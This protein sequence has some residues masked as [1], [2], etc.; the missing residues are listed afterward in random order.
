MAIP[1]MVRLKARV[2]EL[3][4]RMSG[5]GWIAGGKM[6]PGRALLLLTGIVLLG[7]IAIFNEMSPNAQASL[8][9]DRTARASADL[10]PASTLSTDEVTGNTAGSPKHAPVAGQG[11]E[12]NKGENDA[13]P[14]RVAAPAEP[15]FANPLWGLPLARLSTTRERPIFSA[16]R[17]P[18]APTPTYVAPV[19]VSQ[20]AKPPEPERPAIALVGTIIGTDDGYRMAVFR[21]TSTQDVLRLRIGENYHGWVVRL[22]SPREASLVKNGEQAMLELPALWAAPPPPPRSRQQAERDAIWKVGAE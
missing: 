3:R 9:D 6:N 20:P 1:R 2:E 11:T 16:S 7:G 5:R 21:D 10:L 22:I 12:E 17:R 4:T 18:S 19:A 8:L 15:L 13:A 14:R